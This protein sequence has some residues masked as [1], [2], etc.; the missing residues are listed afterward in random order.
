M[1]LQIQLGR[2]EQLNLEDRCRYFNKT[3][4]VL[5]PFQV[6]WNH[7]TLT[8]PAG[9][10]SDGAT[11]APDLGWGWLFH[12]YVYETHCFDDGTPCT[13]Q[14]ADDLLVQVL[15]EEGYPKFSRLVHWFRLLCCC[16]PCA[17]SAQARS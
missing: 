9:Y 3:W 2:A 15:R 17:W 16:F 10:L 12:D 14:E 7:R 8:V 4:R 13:R 11:L 6:T 5:E 1:A